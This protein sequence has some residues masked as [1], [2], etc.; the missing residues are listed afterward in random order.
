MKT[1]TR[2]ENE[3][4]LSIGKPGSTFAKTLTR[5]ENECSLSISLLSSMLEA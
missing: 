3:C 2:I 1:L 5:I 4:S